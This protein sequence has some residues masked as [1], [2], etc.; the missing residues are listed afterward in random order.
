M[1]RDWVWELPAAVALVS[2][3][4]T[5]GI[6]LP[7]TLFQSVAAAALAVGAVEVVAGWAL[8]RRA[9]SDSARSVAAAAT[10][11]GAIVVV[12]ALG[13]TVG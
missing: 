12:V 5:L 2:A 8:F 1:R 11:A 9:G 3:T 10:L 6:G 7:T 13:Q 4:L